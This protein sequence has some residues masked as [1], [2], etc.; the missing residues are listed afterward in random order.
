[1][2][3]GRTFTPISLLA[4]SLL[5]AASSGGAAEMEQP[6][7]AAAPR[8]AG[9]WDATAATNEG[10]E[11][12]SGRGAA[13]RLE[14]AK[15]MKKA[16]DLVE[17]PCLHLDGSQ[18]HVTIPSRPSLN[19]GL[20]TLT[21]WF[22]VRSG[23]VPLQKPVVVKSTPTHTRPWYQY[24][25]FVMEKSA[26]ALQLSCYLGI[27]GEPLILQAEDVVELDTWGLA[28]ATWD[29]K[30][31]RLYW[32]GRQVAVQEGSPG[33]VAGCDTPL[34]FGAYGNLPKSP[35]YCLAGAIASVRLYDGALTAEGIA[36][37]YESEKQAYPAAARKTSTETPYARRLNEAL[38]EKR[39]VLGEQWIAQGD[40][41]HG[42]LEGL[43]RPLFFSTGDEY[44][45]QG[46]HNLIF[47]EEGDRPPYIVPLADGSRIVS[48]IYNSPHRLEVF[49]GGDGL[50]PFGQDLERLEGPFLAGGFYPVLQTRYTDGA[51]VRIA[52]ESFAGR[53]PG[54]DGL[55]ALVRLQIDEKGARGRRSLLRIRLPD[56]RR[57]ALWASGSPRWDEE[58]KAYVYERPTGHGRRTVYL[59]WSP[60]GDLP[61]G[62]RIDERTYQTAHARWRAYWDGILARGCVFQVPEPLVMDAQRNLLIQNL[63]MRWRYTLGPVVYHGE[64]YQPEGSDTVTLLGLYG[65]L[66]AHRDGLSD[67]LPKTKGAGYYT[68]WEWGEKLTHGAHYYLLTRDRD[69]IARHTPDYLAMCRGLAEQMARDPNGLPEKQRYSGDVPEASY[70]TPHLM[71]CWRGLRDMAQ[72]WKET[73]HGVEARLAEET[74]SRLRSALRKALDRSV[75]WLPDGSLFVPSVLLEGQKP[76]DPITETRLGSY[77]N[78]VMPYAYASGFWEPDSREMEGISRYVHRYGGVLLGLLRFN[79]YP[80]R[81]GAFRP[82][83]L[84]G[85][86]T[87]GFDNVYLPNYQRM[88]ADRGEVDRLVLSFYGKLAHGQ[89]RNTFVSGEG[90][91]GGE[92]PGERYRSCYGTPN[93]GNNA[94]F[95]LPLRL[96]LIRETFDAGTGLPQ[97]LYLA[98]AAP[99]P[100]LAPGRRIRVQQAPTCFGP[101]SYTLSVTPSGRRVTAEVEVPARDP[102]EELGLKLR[103]P[104]GRRIRAVTVNGKRHERFDATAETID[105]SGL[106]GSLRVV[107]EC[108]AAP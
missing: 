14:G 81:I 99:R 64:F 41:R 9:H 53:V 31:A 45:Q 96:M 65:H 75:T 15:A 76:F 108:A 8:L 77:W 22:L 104:D 44:K 10:I 66:D 56:G 78:L 20:L 32:N 18:A 46:V 80:V 40:E 55:V 34:L 12:L 26:P 11:D 39:D 92:V 27:G 25:L 4:V 51:G 47:A 88:L 24:G 5:T 90:D 87:T 107:A 6:P 74:A 79:Y 69:F 97:G 35:D 1:M 60:A 86:S 16:A 71:V 7:A 52:Q 105:L 43:L 30:H 54:V 36:R 82:G 73:G 91:T 59:L 28:A 68:N 70:C 50:E 29:G 106:K 61:E 67:L 72:V 84:P 33:K 95:L 3:L 85:Y 38:R 49:V 63:I 17:R 103:L 13:G 62:L 83:G 98:D 19:P 94:A 37:L 100:W 21:A 102:V 42:A 23:Q 93:S 89:T 57:K 58:Q 101:V 48:P 2:I